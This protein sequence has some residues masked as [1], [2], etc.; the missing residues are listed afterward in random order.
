MLVPIQR[1]LYPPQWLRPAEE[2]YDQRPDSDLRANG[3][4]RL[5]RSVSLIKVTRVVPG[6]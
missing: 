6:N 3:Q 2:S 4:V 1:D 5:G